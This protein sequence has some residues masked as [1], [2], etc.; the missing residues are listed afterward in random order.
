[1]SQHW[2]W[3]IVGEREQD[4][5]PYIEITQGDRLIC[6]V[7][8]DE[9]GVLTHEDWENARKIISAPEHAARCERLE[10]ALTQVNACLIRA[11]WT[12]DVND[13]LDIIKAAFAEAE[14]G[15]T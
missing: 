3:R 8:A 15:K 1:M 9:D 7:V 12:H 2:P 6:A 14:E 5:T 10:G 4:G 13:A 11:D